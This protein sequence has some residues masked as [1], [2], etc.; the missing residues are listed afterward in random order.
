MNR[1]D[2]DHFRITISN[3]FVR[4][5]QIRLV[6]IYLSVGGGGVVGGGGGKKKK[7]VI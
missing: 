4:P 6:C 1:I 3:V 5:K 7:T 2:N